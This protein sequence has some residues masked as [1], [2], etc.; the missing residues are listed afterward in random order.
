MIIFD[1]E[2]GHLREGQ[3][4]T[5]IQKIL[6]AA[7]PT[8]PSPTSLPLV[9][10]VGC[11]RSLTQSGNHARHPLQRSTSGYSSESETLPVTVSELLKVI[12]IATVHI[13]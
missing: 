8:K 9:L 1:I 7:P 4:L 3:H 11:R 13:S 5:V 12:M 6:D 10:L 2:Y